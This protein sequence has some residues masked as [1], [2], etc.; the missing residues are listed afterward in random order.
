[1]HG[2]NMSPGFESGPAG[3][4]ESDNELVHYRNARWIYALMLSY[5]GSF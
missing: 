4:K 1:M 5:C 3:H 2:P